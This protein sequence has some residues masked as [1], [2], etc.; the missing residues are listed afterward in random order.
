MPKLKK[1]SAQVYSTQVLPKFLVFEEEM[2]LLCNMNAWEHPS[3]YISHCTNGFFFQKDICRS[4]DVW[5]WVLNYWQI[6]ISKGIPFQY[7]SLLMSFV[8]HTLHLCYEHAN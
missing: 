8:I 6:E 2:D 3:P 4:G 7:F 5:T 1:K